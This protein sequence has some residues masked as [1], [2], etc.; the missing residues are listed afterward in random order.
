MTESAEPLTDEQIDFLRKAADDPW[1]VRFPE[2]WDE[3]KIPL[4]FNEGEMVPEK[5]WLATILSFRSYAEKW[6]RRAA[7]RWDR[8]REDSEI[9]PLRREALDAMACDLKACYEGREPIPMIHLFTTLQH[10]LA[11]CLDVLDARDDMIAKLEARL[12]EYEEE[13]TSKEAR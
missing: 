11:S 10:A 8:A 2:D 13:H 5:V 4:S 1:S 6:R 9:H 12:R 3:H 7:D